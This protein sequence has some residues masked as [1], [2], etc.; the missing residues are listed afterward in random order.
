VV[1]ELTTN[2]QSP[3]S[4]KNKLELTSLFPESYDFVVISEDQ[5]LMTG[6][7]QLVN[8]DAHVHFDK[9]EQHDMLAYPTEKKKYLARGGSSR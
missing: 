1:F 3:V 6:E 2:P 4:V 7:Y 8:P 5:G 9:L